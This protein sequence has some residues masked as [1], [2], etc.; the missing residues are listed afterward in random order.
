MKSVFLVTA[1]M[2]ALCSMVLMS[3]SS[4]VNADATASAATCECCLNCD[5][6]DCACADQDCPCATGGDCECGC[7]CCGTDGCSS[8]DGT[9]TLNADTK[10]CCSDNECVLDSVTT[11]SES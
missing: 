11:D 3:Q 8:K 10:A 5:C 2:G 1:A 9:C 7:P 4:P 6:P